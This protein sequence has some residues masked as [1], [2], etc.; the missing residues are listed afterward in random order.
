MG[1]S[2]SEP[3]PNMRINSPSTLSPM[4]SFSLNSGIFGAQLPVTKPF[5]RKSSE[6]ASR[7]EGKKDERTA[8]EEPSVESDTKK[9][10]G[11][12]AREHI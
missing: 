6:T 3:M 5:I 2:T 4:P 1:I 10:P 7:I 9:A 11:Q 12:F 8:A